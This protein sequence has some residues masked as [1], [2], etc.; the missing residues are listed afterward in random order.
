MSL[1]YLPASRGGPKLAS[2][3]LEKARICCINSR[4]SPDFSQIR[5]LAV[6][7]PSTSQSSIPHH[8]NIRQIS[9]ESPWTSSEKFM[10][11]TKDPLTCRDTLLPSETIELFYLPSSGFCD[12]SYYR[13]PC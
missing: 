12:A 9:T 11:I 3:D 13:L 10:T 2:K 8:P 4:P 1:G 5:F 7:P 6:A